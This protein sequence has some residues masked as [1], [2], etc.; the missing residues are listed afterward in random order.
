MPELL[1][2]LGFR[3][4][5]RTRRGPCV[6]HGGDNPL[7]FHWEETGEWFCFTRCGRGGDKIA[8]VRAVRRCGFREA[9]TFLAGLGGVQYAPGHV[10][11]AEIERR[12][13]LRL[14]AGRAAWHAYD[15]IARLRRYYTDALHRS[16]RLCAAIGKR[17][18]RERDRKLW[19]DLGRLA[20]AQSFYL[21]AFQF[22]N[23]GTPAELARFAFA[24]AAK[25]RAMILEGTP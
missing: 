22:L 15:E 20:P 13:Q 2:E 3:V 10:P 14:R 8:L 16:D 1:A 18:L 21:A 7:A 9:V 12:R 17:L 4:N 11:R 24:G 5:T 19:D 25:R 23:K 6:I